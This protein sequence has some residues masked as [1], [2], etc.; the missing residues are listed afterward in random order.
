[1]LHDEVIAKLSRQAASHRS[2]WLQL[3]EPLASAI[4][5]AGISYR[6]RWLQLSE[7][8][9]SAIGAAG[10][11]Y[12][13]RWLQLSEPLAFSQRKSLAMPIVLQ[14]Y[15]DKLMEKNSPAEM[16]LFHTQLLKALAQ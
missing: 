15:L 3:S 5:A 16:E 8:L 4:G 2:R 10:F 11:S 9:A 6:S 7:P 13:S 1:M 14:L 12:R